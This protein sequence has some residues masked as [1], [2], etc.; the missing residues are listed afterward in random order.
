MHLLSSKHDGGFTNH[1]CMS[2]STMWFPY[3]QLVVYESKILYSYWELELASRMS[4][5]LKGIR[6]SDI[7]T[8][9]NWEVPSKFVKPRLHHI[10]HSEQSKFFY[11]KT[12]TFTDHPLQSWRGESVFDLQML[13]VWLRYIPL[14]C[15]PVRLARSLEQLNKCRYDVA[16]TTRI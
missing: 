12:R 13:G 3:L 10:H 5:H 2:V 1:V 15:L 8:T 11:T 14:N 16:T 6:R 7:W 9:S 4:D